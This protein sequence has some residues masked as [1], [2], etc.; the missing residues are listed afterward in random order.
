MKTLNESTGATHSSTTLT[1]HFNADSCDFSAYFTLFLRSFHAVRATHKRFLADKRDA[2]IIAKNAEHGSLCEEALAIF[3]SCYGAE[4][5]VCALKFM[6]FGGLYLTGGVTNKTM[7][8]LLKDNRFLEAYYDKGRVA[9]LLDRVP[10][11]V[12]KCDDMGKRG[13]HLRAV[14]LLRYGKRQGAG[15][16]S[17]VSPRKVEL[18]PPRSVGFNVIASNDGSD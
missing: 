18:V 8:F 17:T 9:P 3:A 10:L 11:Y 6:P 13:A 12:V 5:G 2:S 1:P 4:T 14:Q 15:E 7:E 16:S